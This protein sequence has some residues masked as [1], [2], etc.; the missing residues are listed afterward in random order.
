LSAVEEGLPEPTRVKELP[1]GV[2]VEVVAPML[3]TLVK[4]DSFTATKAFSPYVSQA[5]FPVLAHIRLA[6][7]PAGTAAGAAG[8]AFEFV[9]SLQ[10]M[11]KVASPLNEAASIRVLA[12]INDLISFILIGK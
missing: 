6:P 12:F 4:I 11:P 10:A 3:S 8:P 5:F 9:L 2:V 1:R 7:G